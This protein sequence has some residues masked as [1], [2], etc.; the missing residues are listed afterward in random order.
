V[1]GHDQSALAQDLHG[2][3][4]RGVRDAVS[5][6]KDRSAGSLSVISPFSIRRAMSSAT[7]LAC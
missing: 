6:A 1:D 2:M 7:G 4:H 3:A 5:S